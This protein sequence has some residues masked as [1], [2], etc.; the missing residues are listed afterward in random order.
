MLFLS[1]E[2]LR[3]N[4]MTKKVLICGGTGLLGP[5]AGNVLS[6]SYSV[7]IHGNSK[8][9][10]CQGNLI[11]Y[12]E[13]DALLNKEMP[14][15]I[16]NLV[17]L[18]NVDTCEEDLQLA[19]N[20]NV[21]IPK[22]LALWCKKNKSLLIQISTDHIYNSTNS[23]EEDVRLV[24][25]YA[26]TKLAGEAPVLIADGI[27]LRTNFFGKSQTEGRTSFSDWVLKS[28]K[29]EDSV[30]LFK[31]VFFNPLSMETLSELIAIVINS[32]RPGVYNLGSREGLSKEVFARTLGELAGLQHHSAKS[33]CF[34]DLD[35]KAARPLDMRM[36]VEKFELT[37]KVILP[38]LKSEIEGILKSGI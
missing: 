6:K 35:L 8:K 11:S 29:S 25:N 19:Y 16:V 24:N 9:A 7:R 15:V 4:L 18:T 20:L 17:A 33:V 12:A 10:D 37:Y 32:P 23:S 28:L 2:T 22:N 38:S 1:F 26:L 34:E 30:N 14:D 5:I 3:E 27:V 31:D 13:T 21:Q 36:N